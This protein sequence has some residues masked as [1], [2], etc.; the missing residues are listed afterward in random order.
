MT[1][2]D[3]VFKRGENPVAGGRKKG[4]EEVGGVLSSIVVGGRDD[5]EASWRKKYT[6]NI[7]IYNL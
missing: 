4:E 6:T 7:T 5:V 2:F 3:V 1:L